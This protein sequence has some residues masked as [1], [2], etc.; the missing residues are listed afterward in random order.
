M[1]GTVR[2]LAMTVL[3]A[4]AGLLKLLVV[5]ALDR[6]AGLGASA[7]VIVDEVEDVDDKDVDDGDPSTEFFVAGF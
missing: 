1:V 5:E 2:L 4:T 6:K 3:D 7:L